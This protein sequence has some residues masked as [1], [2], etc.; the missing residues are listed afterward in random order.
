[1]I[2]PDMEPPLTKE[3]REVADAAIAFIM[4]QPGSQV[5]IP[6]HIAEPTIRLIGKLTCEAIRQIKR[7]EGSC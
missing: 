3:Q 7:E 1:M 4:A 2:P 5:K 6:E